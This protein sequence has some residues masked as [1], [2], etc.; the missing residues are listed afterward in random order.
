MAAQSEPYVKYEEWKM[1]A[2]H[3]IYLWA[4]LHSFNTFSHSNLINDNAQTLISHFF[5]IFTF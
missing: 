3:G 5:I 4:I 2:P 1:N